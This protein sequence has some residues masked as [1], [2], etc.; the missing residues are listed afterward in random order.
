MSDRTLDS[1]VKK[2][3][4]H[5]MDMQGLVMAIVDECPKHK[6]P[7]RIVLQK[8]IYFCNI[9]LDLKARFCAHYYGPYCDEVLEAQ[10]GLCSLGFLSETRFRSESGGWAYEYRLTDD[11]REM[12]R[13]L[14]DS[15]ARISD[16]RKI[17]SRITA[18]PGWTRPQTISC[19]AKVAYVL[20]RMDTPMT[21]AAIMGQAKSFGWT[22]MPDTITEVGSFLSGL[23]MVRTQ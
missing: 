7:G 9:A 4:V 6:A 16:V 10:L 3:G 8:L 5:I 2:A 20:R 18:L 15:D 23:G 13:G 11:G 19:A 21:E 1:Y 17:V 12:L 22:L 14:D